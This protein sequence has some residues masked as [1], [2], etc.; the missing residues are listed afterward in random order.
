MPDSTSCIVVVAEHQ[1]RSSINGGMPVHSAEANVTLQLLLL[2]LMMML[3]HHSDAR[4]F[5]NCC[6]VSPDDERQQHSTTDV[7]VQQLMHHIDA[8]HDEVTW[9][10]AS[11]HQVPVQYSSLS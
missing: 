10:T 1:V 5:S 3:L 7:T 4:A 6:A 9:K 2:L 11:I 8:L